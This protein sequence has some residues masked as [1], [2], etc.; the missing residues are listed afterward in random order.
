MLF[1]VCCSLL[2]VIG[3]LLLSDVLFLGVCY[4]CL[5]YIA[6]Y[7]YLECCL[8][9][10]CLW[11]VCLRC[12]CCSLFVAV[13]CWLNAVGCSL[14]VVRCL[15]FVLPVVYGSACVVRCVLFVVRCLLSVV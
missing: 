15:L 10:V 2:G 4:G 11:F 12:V 7:F 8:L 9:F 6:V 3:S 5:L 1:V 13:R 14:F